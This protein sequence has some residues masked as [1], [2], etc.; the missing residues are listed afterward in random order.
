M[1]ERFVRTLKMCVYVRASEKEI[2]STLDECLAI[3][4]LA[5]YLDKRA[6]NFRFPVYFLCASVCMCL[7]RVLSSSFAVFFSRL[8]GCCI[9]LRLPFVFLSVEYISNPCTTYLY[10]QTHSKKNWKNSYI[11]SFIQ[12]FFHHIFFVLSF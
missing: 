8:R 5:I 4:Y 1:F 9:R 2:S 10:S 11:H 12:C 3:E 6:L 7:G